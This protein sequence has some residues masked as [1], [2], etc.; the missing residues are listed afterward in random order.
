[1]INAI[2][3]SHISK[4]YRI[5]TINPFSRKR[6]TIALR[7][8]SFSCPAQKISCILGPNGAGKTTA[9]KILSGLIEPDS[10]DIKISELPLNEALSRNRSQ[11]GLLTPNERSFFWRL[12]GRQNLD[13]YASLYNLKGS[14]KKKRIGEVIDIVTLQD[15]ADKPFR[16]Y[17]AG[18]RQKLL[19]ARAILNNP[20]I[21]L[22][23][24][25]TTHMDPLM[26]ISIRNLIREKI[27]GE[28]HATVL[29]CTHDL[30]EAQ[31]LSDHLIFLYK[32][33]IRA[34]GSLP[35][36]SKQIHPMY[37]LRME[38]KKF[39]NSGWLNKLPFESR[40][41]TNNS[42]EIDV[43]DCENIPGLIRD[44]VLSGGDLLN[45]QS[46]EKSLTSLFTRFYDGDQ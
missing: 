31:E 13:F 33:V 12:T 5:P 10:G 32:G 19:F 1:M 28:N 44:A 24:E 37:N 30:T 40:N 14:A 9:V 38:F 27:V 45:C 20:S 2:M 11:M 6:E 3:V 35:E 46:S 8:I 43:A 4:T 25:P 42:V 39:P 36:L 7:D 22:L 41:I 26:R 16:L 34:E 15:D 21:L 29:L 18:M 17:S 23:D